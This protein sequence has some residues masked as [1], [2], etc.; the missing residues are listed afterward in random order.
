M[1]GIDV[2]Q[3]QEDRIKKDFKMPAKKRIIL[4]LSLVS[5]ILIFSA[6]FLYLKSTSTSKAH[7][8]ASQNK[9]TLKFQ[10][11]ERDKGN[12]GKFLE[13]ANLPANLLEGI[14]FEL[15]A[16][17]SAALAFALPAQADL[18]IGEDSLS[19]SGKYQGP[20][21]NTFQIEEIKMPTS[22]TLAM[23]TSSLPIF[24]KQNYQIPQNFLTSL[25]DQKK[26]IYL[27]VF[28]EKADW[29]IIFKDSQQ[30]NFSAK[31]LGLDEESFKEEEF[32]DQLKLSLIKA[33]ELKGEEVT[34]AY[35]NLDNRSYLTSSRDSAESIIKIQRNQ[36]DSKTFKVKNALS[37]SDSAFALS[38]ENKDN[39]ND[40]FFS[41]IFSEKP[42]FSKNI[43]K[44]KHLEFAL[45]KDSFSGLIELK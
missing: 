5:I 25:S 6:S 26:P 31:D 38:L 42:A 1:I 36:L 28:G 40:N 3:G 17:S 19:F 10:I 13:K 32:D 15:D 45:R 23:A 12:A 14:T 33:K 4:F 2:H 29:A 44:I 7:L 41:L 18:T 35:F 39:L 21:L 43:K 9:F 27:I 30:E 34:L 16:T 11:K 8:Q 24:L 37:D 20:T 22:A